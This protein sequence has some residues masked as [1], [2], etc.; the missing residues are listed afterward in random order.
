MSVCVCV[1]VGVCVCVCVCV[2]IIRVYIHEDLAIHAITQ[3]LLFHRVNTVPV[4]R[5]DI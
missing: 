3:F 1:C 4:F 2:Y 5:A